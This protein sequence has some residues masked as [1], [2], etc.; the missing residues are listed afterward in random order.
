VT[1]DSYSLLLNGERLM[2][3]SGEFHPWRLPVAGLW[4]DVLEKIKALGFNTVSFYV[5]WGLV[6]HKRGSFDFNGHRSYKPFFDAAKKAGVYLIARPGPYINAEV[7]GNEKKNP[8]AV[9]WK[10]GCADYDRWRLS[11]LG[12]PC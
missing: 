1:W 8:P 11:R 4:L 7:T 5:H 10:Y 9:Y 6:E 2:I 3:W 12:C